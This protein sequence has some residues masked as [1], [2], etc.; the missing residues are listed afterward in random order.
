MN[1]KVDLRQLHNAA[2]GSPPELAMGFTLPPRRY[3]PHEP[4]PRQM[5]FLL[6]P[7]AEAF[8]G[9]AAG[10]V[11]T[12]ALLM[13]AVQLVGHPNYHALLL[14]PVVLGCCPAVNASG[15]KLVA[16]DNRRFRGPAISD[17]LRDLFSGLCQVAAGLPAPPVL[18]HSVR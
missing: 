1:G 8:F 10:P 9:G 5:A 4:R 3:C 16:G 18:G 14:R 11:K 2:P 17:V 15:L 7:R 13:G 12:E 6:C